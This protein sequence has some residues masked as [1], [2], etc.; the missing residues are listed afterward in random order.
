LQRELA[1]LFRRAR[2]LVQ[3]KMT[4]Y[5]EHAAVASLPEDCPYSLAQ[6]L[7]DWEPEAT[8]EPR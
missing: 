3:R 6:I 1:D 4:R 8:R 5:G 2:R 7:G